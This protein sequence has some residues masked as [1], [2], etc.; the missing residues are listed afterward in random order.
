MSR[1]V[2]P[3]TWERFVEAVPYYATGYDEQRAAVGDRSF[4][5][6]GL[7]YPGRNSTVTPSPGA[8]ITLTIPIGGSGHG[9]WIDSLTCEVIDHLSG[10]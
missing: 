7:R 9:V 1:L 3:T 4:Y 2:G 5:Y 8:G 6:V 10:V